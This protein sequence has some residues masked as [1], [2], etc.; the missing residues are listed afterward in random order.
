MCGK[1]RKIIEVD[2]PFYFCA[3]FFSSPFSILFVFFFL[4]PFVKYLQ[5]ALVWFTIPIE[6]MVFVHSDS[7]AKAQRNHPD[8]KKKK[9]CVYENPTII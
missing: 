6:Q 2:G 5:W 1:Y 9:L 8:K 7:F 3:F 4:D